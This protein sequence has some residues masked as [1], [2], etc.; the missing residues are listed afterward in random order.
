MRDLWN[1]SFFGQGDVSPSHS[2]L[3]CSVSGSRAKH[4]VSSP[5]INFVKKIFV[6][7]GH[8]NNALARCD[9]IFPLLRCQGVW[10]KTCT[11]LSLSQ[12]VFQNPKNYSP[13]N[14]QRFCYHSWCDSTVTFDQISN[15]S[16][17][18]HSSSWFWM[19]TSFV[20]FY[21]LPSVSKLRIP[22][23]NVWSVQSL[24]PI[25]LLHQY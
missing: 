2:G 12:I 3:C 13:G 20:I 14:F 24:V 6:S 25:S 1:F 21:Q 8:Y 17:V 5:V 19:A 22:P 18:Y 23:K 16:N 10:N 15:S 11:R 4:Q 9:L 7:I